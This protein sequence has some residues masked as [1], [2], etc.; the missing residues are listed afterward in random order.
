METYLLES[1]KKYLPKIC[2]LIGSNRKLLRKIS[3]YIIRINKLPFD[4]SVDK[5]HCIFDQIL[6]AEQGHLQSISFLNFIDEQCFELYNTVNSKF[7]SK[8]E[9]T[10][11]E[12]LLAMDKDINIPNNPAYQNFLAEIAGLLYLLTNS[13]TD[14]S[15]DDIEG[16]LSNGK[17]A[18]FVFKNIKTDE[19]IYIE[20]VS[21][22]EIQISKI[23][24]DELLVKFIEDKIDIK[25]ASKIKDLQING[26]QLTIEGK[27]VTF[28]I[29]PI[30][31][32]E[33]IDLL[34][35]KIAFESLEINHIKALQCCSL[36][37]QKMKDGSY[38]YTFC[39]VNN[40]LEDCKDQL[41]NDK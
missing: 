39:T 3:E 1:I 14:Y 28:V 23:E 37:V 38:I 36:R 40:T 6:M 30:I 10:I 20:L 13:K 27:E 31:W 11:L 7:K 22:N 2:K 41:S 9:K 24:S 33:I 21:F 35:N 26:N 17:T 29:L 34:P 16:S 25:I 19:L 32:A 18:D 5:P 12:M 4:Y 8:I 15:L